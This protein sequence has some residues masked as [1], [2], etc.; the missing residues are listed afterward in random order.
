MWTRGE[1]ELLQSLASMR[2][3]KHVRGELSYLDSRDNQISDLLRIIG[4]SAIER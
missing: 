4:K 1:H 2:Q 3:G